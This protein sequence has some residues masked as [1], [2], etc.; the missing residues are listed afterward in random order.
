[1]IP[2]RDDVPSRTFPFVN[3]GLIALNILFFLF[4]LGMGDGLE[5]FLYQAAVIPAHYTGADQALGP[6]EIVT[7]TL[8]PSLALPVLLSMFLHGGW[9]H[10]I[11]NMLYLWIFGDNVEDRMGHFRYLVFYL[12]CG[13]IASYTHIWADPASRLPSIG[14]SGAIAG[15]LGAYITLYPNARVVMLLP[16]GIFMELVQVPAF[17]FLGIWFLQ[18]FFSGALSLASPSATGGV[19]W[20]AHIGGFAA[21]F[22]LVR[23]FVRRSLPAPSARDLWWGERR[24]ARG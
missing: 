1:M 22:A 2:L 24:R 13:W 5:R 20:W 15:V 14:A 23:V 21:G 8:S 16:L 12:A 4:E 18:Q 11:G 19:A 17:F 3:I 9:M 10:I 7:T 6:L